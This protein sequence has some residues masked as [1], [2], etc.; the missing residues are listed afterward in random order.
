MARSLCI[1]TFLMI[2]LLISTGN[3]NFYIWSKQNNWIFKTMQNMFYQKILINTWCTNIFIYTYMCI[4]NQGY[5]KEK[6]NAWEN[7]G[8]QYPQGCAQRW[9]A[10]MLAEFKDITTANVKLRTK[11]RFVIVTVAE[12]KPRACAAWGKI[13][14]ISWTFIDLCHSVF[15]LL[16]VGVCFNVFLY[17][18]WN[19]Q[20]NSHWFGLSKNKLLS[21]KLVCYILFPFQIKYSNICYK[22]NIFQCNFYINLSLL[23]QTKLRKTISAIVFLNN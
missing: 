3:I 11:Q 21:I 17:G 8:A 22:I 7:K 2:F 9:C 15:E 1:V 5:R 14:S 12:L 4:F 19:N 23:F 6:L 20:L 18:L 16:Y 13:C 10:T